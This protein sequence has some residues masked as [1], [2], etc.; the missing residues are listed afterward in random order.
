[1]S[2]LKRF[3]LFVCRHAARASVGLFVPLEPLQHGIAVCELCQPGP[4]VQHHCQAPCPGASQASAQQVILPLPFTA[5]RPHQSRGQ[6]KS[7]T[8]SCNA[9]LGLETCQDHVPAEQL[10]L[11]SLAGHSLDATSLEQQMPA[12]HACDNMTGRNASAYSSKNVASISQLAA[13]MH[14]GV[15]TNLQQNREKEKRI[16]SSSTFSSLSLRPAEGMSTADALRSAARLSGSQL[17]CT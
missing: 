10:W 17:C 14:I 3:M 5:H 16:C 4:A 1:M 12:V 11:V 7:I 9:R 15:F 8:E 6:I 13:N 2:L